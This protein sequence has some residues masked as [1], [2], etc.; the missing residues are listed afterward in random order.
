M[1]SIRI[2]E[3][4]FQ[5]SRWAN[6]PIAPRIEKGSNPGS[7]RCNFLDDKM[8]G[9]FKRIPLYVSGTLRFASTFTD[10]FCVM[11]LIGRGSRTSNKTR[12]LLK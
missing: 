10:T 3:F 8:D 12:A 2:Y 7:S 6:A 11:L 5:I 4:S 9:V 1:Y